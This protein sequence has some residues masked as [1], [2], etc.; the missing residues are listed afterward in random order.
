MTEGKLGFVSRLQ[1]GITSWRKMCEPALKNR[2]KMLSYYASGYYGREKKASSHVMKLTQ[3][4]IDII[5][6]YLSMT[7]PKVLVE[8][9]IPQLKPWARTT[10]LAMNHLLEEIKFNKYTMRPGILNSMFGQGIFKTGIMK[11]DEL[12]IFGYLHDVGQ[13]YCDVVDD[14]DYIGDVSAKN[15]EDFEFEGHRY[16][17][18]TDV[19]KDF[20]G[21]KHADNIK[22][23]F[24]LHGSSKPELIAKDNIEH[25]KYDSLYEWSEFIDIWLPREDVIITIRPEG[26]GKRILRTVEWDGPEGGPFDVLSYKH[27]PE[28]PLP[29]PP[30]WGW[31]DFDTMVNVLLNKMRNQ[32][33]REKKVVLYEQGVEKE[34]KTIAE[35]PD[36]SML[37]VANADAYREV[38]Y[39]GA[40]P[41]NYDYVNYLESQFSIQGGNLYVMGGR[42]IQAQTLGQEQ[43]LQSN[44]SRILDDMVNEVY[45]IAGNV[46]K[47]MA[48]FLWTDPL[49][50]IPVIKRLPG[51][52]DLEVIFNETDKEGDFYDFNFKV[53]PYS[54]QRTSPQLKYQLLT[55]FL[56]GWIIP[57]Y[58]LAAQQGNRL[59]I[60]QVTKELA[61]FLDINVDSWYQT[62]VP[63]VTQGPGPYQPTE[64]KIKNSGQSDDRF[65]ADIGSR[66]ANFFQ[67]ETSERAGKPSPPNKK[68]EG[69]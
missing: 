6:P 24:S 41:Q 18:P 19:A 22:P 17:M 62:A 39:G 7:E 50:E 26:K 49:I 12:E 63:E 23:D 9:R 8:A 30:V 35:A 4:G 56:N 54:M 32:A 38:E 27:F 53:E 20:F 69:V 2:L 1:R 45:S 13:V 3:R 47:K 40:S 66:L 65:G 60:A 36:G 10:E 58:Q 29:I 52:A 25:Y 34:A 14:S 33:E 42:N 28:T 16:R 15:R 31:I 67:Y 11:K 21:E 55:Q 68:K 44:A 5:V 64:G 51:V 46:L 48:W 59:N 57:T 61:R 43:M 37:G